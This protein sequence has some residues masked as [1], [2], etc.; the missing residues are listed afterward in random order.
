MGTFKTA[1][2]T[3]LAVTVSTIVGA[4]RVAAAPAIAAPACSVANPRLDRPTHL[5]LAAAA[6]QT[7]RNNRADMTFA[8]RRTVDGALQVEARGGRPVASQ[9]GDERRQLCAGARGAE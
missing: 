7:Q 1:C 9:N 5:S 8:S 2:L 6:T 3:S 4:T